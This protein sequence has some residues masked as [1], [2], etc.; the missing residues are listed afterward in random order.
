[1]KRASKAEEENAKADKSSSQ[2]N[3]RNV[4]QYLESLNRKKDESDVNKNVVKC[5]TKK[6]RR[7]TFKS[8]K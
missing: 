6:I 8:V 4:S 5:Q 1:M 2:S 7:K 3:N